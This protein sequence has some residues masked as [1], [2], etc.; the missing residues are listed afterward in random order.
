[1]SILVSFQ[2][3]GEKGHLARACPSCTVPETAAPAAECHTRS[4]STSTPAAP[5]VLDGVT[6]ESQ[7]EGKWSECVRETEMSGERENM[8]MVV[9]VTGENGNAGK[10]MNLTGLAIEAL[11]GLGDG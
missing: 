5:A 6:M 2:Y 11:C 7:A 3:C 10:V 1:M 8:E 4:H 9:E